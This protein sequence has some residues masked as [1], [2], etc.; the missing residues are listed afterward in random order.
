MMTDRIT[1]NEWGEITRLARQIADCV[2]GDARKYRAL[3][4]RMLARIDDLLDRYGTNPGVL[5]TRADYCDNPREAVRLLRKAYRLSEQSNDNK[6]MVLIAGSLA[7]LY[8]RTLHRYR[9]GKKWLRI[10]KRKLIDYPDQD[11]QRTLEELT[12]EML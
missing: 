12:A 6:N 8:V 9:D 10:L 5:A 1:K 7:E 11:E 2:G 3:R 4:F